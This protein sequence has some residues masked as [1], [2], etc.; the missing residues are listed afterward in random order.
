[1]AQVVF[2]ANKQSTLL[3][4]AK[5]S[6]V[7]IEEFQ[8][9]LPRPYPMIMKD[10]HV[11][12]TVNNLDFAGSSSVELSSFG[13]I[14]DLYIKWVVTWTNGSA[15]AGKV[16]VSKNL[17]S[18]IVKR[19]ALMNSSREIYQVFGDEILWKTRGIVD[20][21]ERAKWLMAGDAN[22]ELLPVTLQ[23]AGSRADAGP[24]I[25][26]A[27][28][29][30]NS[31]EFYSKIPF[32]FFHGKFQS[33]EP[34]KTA[35]NLRFSETLRLLI[36]TNPSHYVACGAGGTNEVLLNLK[37]ASCDV[38]AHYDIVEPSDLQKIESQF[39]MGAPM[40]MLNGNSVM[41]ESSITAT[42]SGS[43]NDAVD[44][45]HE[46][47]LYNTNLVQNFIVAITPTRTKALCSALATG[48]AAGTSN[49]T[50]K[51]LVADA[52]G[53]NGAISPITSL[54]QVLNPHFKTKHSLVVG[55]NSR[56]GDD[57]C[58]IKSLQ[59]KSSGRVLVDCPTYKQLLM[60]TTDFT[61]WV[62]T[63]GSH[64]EIN[65]MVDKNHCSD[66]NIYM[67]PMSELSHANALTGNLALK[68]LSTIDFK[69]TFQARQGVNYT[70]KIYSNYQGITS[71]ETSSGRIIS[72][73]S[74]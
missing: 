51:L 62:D 54:V 23:P 49:G 63:A 42:G 66:A 27:N 47:K 1:M 50:D 71:T 65:S 56:I 18:T 40:S 30:V 57:Y 2:N 14:R 5:Q 64:Q 70:V 4:S 29:G 25:N 72:S 55:G 15:Q 39:S 53:A 20:K 9:D 37:I 12:H 69:I 16:V 61:N 32:S 10:Y 13:T 26:T 67:I 74:S 46:V 48:V 38:F 7:Q 35:L 3:N 21:G 58:K 52:F 60:T 8:Y 43:A 59:I 41:T 22:L 11:K 6:G 28:D 34:R 24:V 19:V 17:F 73:V 44:C 36:E 31:L 45:T 33:N 68:G